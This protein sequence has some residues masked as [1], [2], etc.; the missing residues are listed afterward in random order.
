M[1]AGLTVRGT[2]FACELSALTGDALKGFEAVEDVDPGLVQRI[3]EID[4]RIGI[5]MEKNG[6][7]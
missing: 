4:E 7:Q 3:K 5:F 6:F 2:E 1:D